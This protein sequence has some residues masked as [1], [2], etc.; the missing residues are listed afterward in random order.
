M[1][2]VFVTDTY[3]PD[4]NG[5]A[6]TLGRLVK[7]L[8]RKNHEV[9]IIHTA[10][11]GSDE[12]ETPLRGFGLPVYKEVRVGL[13]KPLRFKKEWR[14]DRPD[15]VYVATESPMGTSA[16]KACRKLGIPVVMGFHTNF[17]QYLSRYR[18]EGIRPMAMAYL[19]KAH[20]RADRTL[21]PTQDVKERLEECGFDKLEILG[22]GVDTR[23][24]S[25]SKKSLALRSEWGARP[26]TPV[27][28]VVGRVAA[29][30]NLELAI[31]AFEKMSERI[32]DLKCVV[33]G[34]GPIRA[35]LEKKYPQVIFAGMRQ[36]EDLATH[37]ASADVLLFPSETETFGNV[38]LEGMASGLVTVT[39]DYAASAAHV[40]QIG[41]AHV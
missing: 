41:R 40:R 13:P 25:P 37:Y 39:Y 10:E 19:R 34:D 12:D 17:D 3:A 22:R 9:H 4:V 21:V 31:R 33:V 26:A 6:M 7:G 30:K 24:F 36:G 20:A 32:P 29:E 16:V 27:A 23:L 1:K 18:L 2:I 11:A 15:C 5:V 8:R 28:I 35:S 38:V 14:E